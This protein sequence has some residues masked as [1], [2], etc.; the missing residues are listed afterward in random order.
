M[1]VRTGVVFEGEKPGRAPRSRDTLTRGFWIRGSSIRFFP[2]GKELG[3]LGLLRSADVTSKA[4][5][6]S[7]VPVLWFVVGPIVP[8]GR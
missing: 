7:S 1:V 3:R 5:E 4:K 8:I 2:S 6:W